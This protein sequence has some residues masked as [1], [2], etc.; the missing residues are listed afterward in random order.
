M[1]DISLHLLDIAE[2]SVRAG[3]SEVLIVINEDRMNHFMIKDNGKGMDSSTIDKALD[4]FYTTKEERKK[5]V[6]LGLPLLKQNAQ[7]C[8]GEF[9][10]SS[11]P[12]K[13]TVIEWTMD[14]DNIDVLP[15]GN[16]TET[17]WAL[18]VFYPETDFSIRHSRN[19]ESVEISSYEIREV[20]KGMD[21]SHPAV[22]AALKQFIK[23]QENTLIGGNQ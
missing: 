11:E 10:I 2:N 12:G 22:A 13:G 9:S 18:I 23:E 3:A 15:M 19:N 1:R 8:G 17:F 20:F 5:K 14:P 7:L 21:I 16:L 4:P 6:G